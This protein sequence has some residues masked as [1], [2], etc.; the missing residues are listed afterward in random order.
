[1]PRKMHL[2][3][4]REIIMPWKIVFPGNREIKMHKKSVF[5]ITILGFGGNI[6][7]FSIF[8]N[9]VFPKNNALIYSVTK[10]T[11]FHTYF[12]S[13]REMNNGAKCNFAQISCR[14]S[15]MK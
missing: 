10:N 6:I 14:E 1:M 11:Q 7:Q 4:N 3:L 2:E 5:W 15:F 13:N 8:L 9:S 12:F